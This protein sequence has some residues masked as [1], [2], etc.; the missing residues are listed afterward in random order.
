MPNSYMLVR[1]RKNKCMLRV[2]LL[3]LVTSYSP[4]S[5]CWCEGENPRFSCTINKNSQ[6]RIFSSYVKYIKKNISFYQTLL[7]G[8]LPMKFGRT[9]QCPRIQKPSPPSGCPK[10]CLNF[11]IF[12]SNFFLTT[13]ILSI[14]DWFM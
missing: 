12:T 7:F 13:R 8:T 2:I 10:R 9:K 6:V 11:E 5:C 3:T 1:P 4:K 14:Y